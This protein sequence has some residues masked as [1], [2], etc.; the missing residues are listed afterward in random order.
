MIQDVLKLIE[1]KE[2]LQILLETVGIELKEAANN[3]DLDALENCDYETMKGLYN[4]VQYL[5]DDER[6]KKLSNIIVT[7][8]IL[9]YPQL[10]KPTYYPE[11]D[12]LNISSDEKLRL[13]RAAYMNTR[14]YM[15]EDNLD[16]LEYKLSIQDLELLKSIGIVEKKYS[17]KCK[18]CGDPCITISESD[19]EKYKRVFQLT[20][21]GSSLTDEQDK[22]LDEL[23]ENG[24]Y[25]ISV[26][27]MDCDSECEITNQRDL[28]DYKEHI[29]E[30]YKVEKNPDLTYEKL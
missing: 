18:V 3:L 11:I 16:K 15:N 17:F 23:Y 28:D 21:I 20:E 14:F 8:K 13:D 1:K 30:I 4:Q 6:R 10:L 29:K 26:C 5:I 2:K 7:K 24:V 12:T 25:C 27:C 9:K 19:L 22:E